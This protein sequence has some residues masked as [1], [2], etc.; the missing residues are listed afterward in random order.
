[1]L[2]AVWRHAAVVRVLLKAGAKLDQTDRDGDT[3]LD[4][5]EL[6]KDPECIELIRKVG[7]RK[8]GKGKMAGTKV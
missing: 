7:G 6:G 8:A 2:P 4:H 1:M 3:V 5:A